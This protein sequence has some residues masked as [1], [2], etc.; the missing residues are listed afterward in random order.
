[1]EYILETN[2]LK[3]QYKDFKALNGL[4]MHVPKG[5][6]Y[7]FVWK[8]G[9]GKT[10]LIR[11]IS[12]LQMPTSGDFKIYGINYKDSGISNARKKM[13]AV[14]MTAFY[15]RFVNIIKQIISSKWIKEMTS[16]REVQSDYFRR[17]KYGYLWWGIDSKKNIYSAIGNSGNVIYINSEKN[18]VIAVQ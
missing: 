12:G 18:I 16:F 15:I 14:V 7:W 11:L 6:I 8:N 4:T 1:M 3:K 10:T 13:G 9:A 2:E 17:M 5:L